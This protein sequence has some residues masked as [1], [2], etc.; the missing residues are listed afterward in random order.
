MLEPGDQ[1]DIWVIDKRLGAGGMGSVYRCHNRDAKRILA[2]IKVL[3]SHV[4][5]HPEA[6]RRFIREAEILFHL[7]H[8]NIVKVRNVRVE[9]ATPYIEMEF[10]RGTSIEDRLGQGPIPLAQA[11]PQFGQIAS[12]VAYLHSRG[13][14]HRDIKPANLLTTSDGTVKLVDFGL[15]MEADTTRLTQ[16]NM[17]FGTVSY[18]PPEWADPDRLDP[19]SWD[20]YAIGVVFWEMLTGEVAFPVSGEGSARQQAFQVVMSKQNHEPL[21]PGEAFPEDVRALIRDLTR[22]DPSARLG[23]ASLLV[24]RLA[25]IEG[26]GE[27]PAAPAPRRPHSEPTLIPRGSTGETFRLDG[28]RS[29]GAKPTLLPAEDDLDEVPTGE[30]PSPSTRATPVPSEILTADIDPPVAE[31]R[32]GGAS[33]WVIASLVGVV[34][35]LLVGVAAVAAAQLLP[36]GTP[37]AR[38]VA[39]IVEGIGDD[40][41][42]DLTL[43]MQGPSDVDGRTRVFNGVAPGPHTVQWAVGEGCDAADCRRGRCLDHCLSG[44]RDLEVEAGEGRLGVPFKVAAPA[45][46][47]VRVGVGDVPKGLDVAIAV[48]GAEGDM[49]GPVW[50]GPSVRP[51]RYR[52]RVILGDCPEADPCEDDCPAGCRDAVRE[53]S[54]PP[55][56]GRHETRLVV[57]LPEGRPSDTSPDERTPP[58]GTPTE[59]GTTEGGTTGGGTPDAG[60]AD[61]GTPDATPPARSGRPVTNAQYATWLADHPDWHQDPAVA[62]GR[63][64]G[65]YLMGWDALTPPA[66]QGNLPVQ[67]VPHGAA[68]AYCEGRGGLPDV[69]DEPTTWDERS[70]GLAFEWRMASGRPA[71]L[72]G[73]SG[74]PNTI[75]RRGQSLVLTGFRC[76]R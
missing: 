51:G 29:A 8:P 65:Q 44:W 67:H 59:G 70:T 28:P 72:D 22:A 75:F 54:V 1:I 46:R 47:P 12:A 49:A 3:E 41:E 10:V 66:G 36:T 68:R 57:P 14:R 55:G 42:A 31:P 50:K 5:A 40:L 16:N 24:E 63:A 74:K 23:S 38:S 56:D 52:A 21:D 69:T 60:T 13:V 2:A 33:G 25:A 76:K 58:A 7:E 43:D 4:A 34:V 18:A 61:G 71:Y 17:S 6:R 27:L 53:L 73:A 37:G 9:S 48:E 30:E 35:L 39:L 19:V 11:L 15:A 62:A 45:P 20:L 26:V 32:R 64:D